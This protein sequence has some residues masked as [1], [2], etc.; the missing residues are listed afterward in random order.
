M[1]LKVKPCL[2]LNKLDRLILELCASPMEAYERLKQIIMDVNMIM[3]AFES[4]RF[5]NEANAVL[6][7]E[8]AKDAAREENG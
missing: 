6:A 8:D 3:S 2:V 7:Y 5:I 1:F 4:E